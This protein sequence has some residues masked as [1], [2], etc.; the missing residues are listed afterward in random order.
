MKNIKER[1]ISNEDFMKYAI[2]EAKTSA[3]KGEVPIGAVIVK[4]GKII[5]KGRNMRE[6]KQNALM[7]AEVVAIQKAC[8]K[9][10]SWRLE[11]CEM[12]VTLEPCPMCAGAIINARIK[13]VVYGAKEKTSHD[14]LFEMIL[15]SQ[16]LNHKCEFM[17]DEISQKE[18]SAILT[19]FFKDKRKS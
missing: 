13:K 14:N 3:K 9:L 7:H 10:H 6:K 11:N 17:Q 19:N 5:S 8:K 18:C 2:E 4:D 16:R 15:T 1:K 12:Y